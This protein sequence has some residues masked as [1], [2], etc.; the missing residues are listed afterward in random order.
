M[1]DAIARQ[2]GLLVGVLLFLLRDGAAATPSV[3]AL[4]GTAAL[5]TYG[6]LA[7][8]PPLWRRMNAVPPGP[9][10]AAPGPS[11]A[12]APHPASSDA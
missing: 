11:T 6:T 10:P 5:L 4:A 3:L 12:D 7:L 8:A 2:T 9:L 1:N